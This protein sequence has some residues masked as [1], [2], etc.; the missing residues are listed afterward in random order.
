MNTVTAQVDATRVAGRRYPAAHPAADAPLL[1]TLHGGLFTGRY[2]EVAGS[3]AGSFVD[4]AN[5]NGFD[6]LVIDRPGYGDSGQPADDYDYAFAEQARVL[7]AALADLLAGCD[8]PPVVL[9]GHSVGG[10]IAFEIAAR[11]PAWNLVGL[12]ATGMGARIPT[13]GAAE[14]L[15][16]LPLSG[17]V[18]VPIAERENLWY[19]PPGSY[20]TTGVAAARSS[21]APAPM[22]ELT[23]AP[24][25]AASRLDA[26]APAIAVPIYHALAEFDAL[27]D[28]STEA[29]QTFLA[30]F[31]PQQRVHSEIVDGVGHCI[32]H[33][34]IGASVHYRQLAF[35]HECAYQNNHH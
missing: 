23:T 22:I 27:W 34:L 28:G 25:W 4:I 10:M 6:V 9:V 21:Y 26:V 1:V 12:A 7:D 13:G 17:V 19:G 24:K 33:H 29:R 5:R 15:G 35:A 32:D 14:Q 11:G 3:A 8:N 16:A 30:K 20:T 2:F 18:D 31:T